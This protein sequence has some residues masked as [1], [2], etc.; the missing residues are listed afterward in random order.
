M[1]ERLLNIWQNVKEKASALSSRTKK[2]IIGAL[3]LVIVVSVGLAVWLNTRPYEVLFSEL[4][5]EE[6]SEIIGKLQEDGVDYKYQNDGT[7]LVPAA[8]EELLKAQLVYEGYPKSGF[9]YSL[10]SEK[11]SL[12]TTESEKAHYELVDL[13]NKIGATI[14]L[15]PNIKDAKVIIALG[16]DNRYVLNNEDKTEASASVTV[17]TKDGEK[18]PS[19]T[20]KAIQRLVSKSIP[21]VT[22]E[23]VVV[24]CNGQDVTGDEDSE[25]QTLASKL[26]NSLERD[27][28]NRIKT[29]VS[30]LLLPIYGEGH[31]EVS[32]KA[33]I[34][35]NKKLRE[36]INYSAEDLERNTGVISR[37]QAGWE[38]NRENPVE[39]GVPGTETNSDIP[40][41][42]RITSDGTES[43]VGADGDINYLVD[44]LKEQTE[45]TAGDLRDLSV[46]VIIDGNTLGSLDREELISLV[47]RAAGIDPTLQNER[48]EVLNAPFY[49]EPAEEPV[50]PAGIFSTFT[51][52]Q[53]LILAAI[54]AAVLLLLI[55]VIVLLVRRRRKK[56]R[57]EEEAAAA[58][59]AEAAAA[60]AME[61]YSQ[62]ALGAVPV[63]DT[64][65]SGMTDDLL[66]LQN[67][68]SLELKNKI[69]EF[70]EENPEIAAQLLKRW[71]KG[72][73]SDG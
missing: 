49:T 59:A 41:Y 56:R 31:F 1:K 29:A 16:E 21:D 14:S 23:N 37:E 45:V 66:N 57:L 2:L 47:A 55:L 51:Q 53:L 13:Q 9:T 68:R 10:Y 48:V 40:I 54:A 65:A 3:A 52:T 35:I 20:V 73:E 24:L 63:A 69:R 36:L 46:A 43:F 6:A 58:A 62:A 42:T 27:M 61:E 32:V 25:E 7:I 44:Q 12:T 26:K 39:G 11:V 28:E 4:T 30:N 18:I 72:G 5:N 67:E 19:S 71:L 38:I 17:L 60:A 8:Q 50:S 33:D 34:D 22:F 70:S 15:F 64:D